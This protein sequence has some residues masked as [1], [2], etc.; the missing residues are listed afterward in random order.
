MDKAGGIGVIAKRLVEGNYVDPSTLTCTGNTF[1]EEAAKAVETPGQKVI[2]QIG[3]PVK[4]TGGIAI[5]HGTLAPDGCVI[6][7]SGHNK[8]RHVGPARVFEK[9][10]DA[11]VA[12]NEGKINPNDVMLIR[13]EG[14]KG[15]PGMREMLLVTSA[16]VGAG[17]GDTVALL[18]DGRF[19]GATHGFMAAHIAPEA[20]VGG[21]VAAVREGDIIDIDVDAGVINL[22]IPPEEFALRMASFKTPA[23]KYKTGVF[24]KYVTLVGSS[25]TGAVTGA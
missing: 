23:P 3:H 17:L 11:I 22:N 10:E 16:V 21:P 13:Y 9:E 2:H 18:T 6:K 24:A 19:S 14:P 15:G 8:R 1:G 25:A 4:P 7:L 12:V 5:L 20:H